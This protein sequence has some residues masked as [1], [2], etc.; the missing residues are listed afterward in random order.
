MTLLSSH[1][2][3]PSP[4]APQDEEKQSDPKYPPSE[5]RGR[6]LSMVLD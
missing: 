4:H 6:I 5:F 1:P 2:L 3:S